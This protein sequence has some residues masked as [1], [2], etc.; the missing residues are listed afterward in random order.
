[1]KALIK[2]QTG[3]SIKDKPKNKMGYL[4]LKYLFIFN[5][6]KIYKKKW[7]KAHEK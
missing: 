2:F 5:T 3:L 4:V 7:F 1:M 6:I